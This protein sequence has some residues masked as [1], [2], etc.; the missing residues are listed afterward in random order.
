M[1]GGGDSLF[2][3]TKADGRDGFASLLEFPCFTLARSVCPERITDQDCCTL[4][5][6]HPSETVITNVA[7]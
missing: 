2:T 1:G 5:Y 4:V 6:T 3:G 7:V